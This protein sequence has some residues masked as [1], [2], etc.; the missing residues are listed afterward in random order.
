[1][2]SPGARLTFSDQRATIFLFVNVRPAGGGGRLSS[3]A[4]SREPLRSFS[5][6]AGHCYL[7]DRALRRA[8]RNRLRRSVFAE[9]QR[10]LPQ[11][12]NG[13]LQAVDLSQRARSALRGHRGPRGRTGAPGAAGAQG[14]AGATGSAGPAGSIGPPG[15]T[16]PVGATGAT[17]P[18]GPPGS[19][20]WTQAYSE[21]PYTNVPAGT[22]ASAWALS[23]SDG[24]SS[25]GARGLRT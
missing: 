7:D 14:P 18:Q 10:R 2:R 11:V 19:V 16:G 15:N 5:S 24:R 21:G 8:G 25:V 22:W 6:L 1:V 13:S 3:E 4:G 20:F 23:P 12:I 9:E 17:G